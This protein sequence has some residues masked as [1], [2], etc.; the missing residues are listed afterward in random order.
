M[1]FSPG[2]SHLFADAL[3]CPGLGQAPVIGSFTLSP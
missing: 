2:R 3:D 1:M